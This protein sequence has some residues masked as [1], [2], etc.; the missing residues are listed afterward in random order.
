[1]SEPIE[2]QDVMDSIDQLREEIISVVSNIENI[3]DR[4]DVIE[5]KIRKMDDD[6]DEIKSDMSSIIDESKRIYQTN[7]AISKQN[8][9]LNTTV[10][11][12]NEN[13][14]ELIKD[15]RDKHEITIDTK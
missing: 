14:K 15:L 6:I 1:M 9:D 2:L 7:L 4:F 11:L 13:I 5:S 8:D 3:V 12:L 10:F